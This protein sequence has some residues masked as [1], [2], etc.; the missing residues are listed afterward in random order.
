M[1]LDIAKAFDSVSHAKLIQS[2]KLYGINTALVEWMKEF[3]NNRTQHVCVGTAISASL[4]VVSGVPQGGVIAPL[5]FVIY[6]NSLCM[7]I[8]SISDVKIK[9]FA[10]DAKLY[11]ENPE[12]LQ[13]SIEST[14]LWINEHQL[15]VASEKC[16]YLNIC[17]N[18]LR[19]QPSDVPKY[20]ISSNILTRRSIASDLGVTISDDL[21]WIHQVDYVHKKASTRSYLI[22]K[23]MKSKNIWTLMHLYKTYIRPIVEFN[24]NVWSPYNVQDIIRI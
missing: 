10:D 24:T 2:L 6:L 1:Y 3:L 4:K 14:L 13:R 8:K 9:L 20:K 16:F 12:V 18:R 19:P 11:S 7:K 15:K 17:K 22:L 23:C 5:V 21:K